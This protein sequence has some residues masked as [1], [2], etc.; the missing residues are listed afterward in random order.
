[1][2]IAYTWSFPVLN[3]KLHEDGLTNVVTNVHWIFHADDGEGHTANFYGTT[4]VPSPTG[5]FTLF[6][7]LTKNQVQGWVVESMG[8]K[9]ID[10]MID[11]AQSQIK[12]Q[13]NPTN[14]VL[15]AP[16]NQ[17]P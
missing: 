2:A 17:L 8:Q 1:M 4:S 5:N 12:L 11:S 7:N 10:Q 13:I 14:A 3:V 9:T 6:E 16:W 15:P